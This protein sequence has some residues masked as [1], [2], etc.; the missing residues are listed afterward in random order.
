MV[1][2]VKIDVEG[3]ELDVL[4]GAE[5]LIERDHPVFLVEAES[6]HRADAPRD[7]FA[8][9]AGRNYRGVFIRDKQP[10]SIDLFSPEMQNEKDLVG[11][12]TR[13]SSRYV[14]NF[15]FLPPER[16]FEKAMSA[17][18]SMLATSR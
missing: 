13:E 14:N 9:F 1:G 4:A 7:V 12:E 10:Y 11:Y 17:F 5:Q 8:F 3:H 15:I 6:R 18:S 2:F 16:D